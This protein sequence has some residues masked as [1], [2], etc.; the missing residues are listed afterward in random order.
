MTPRSSPSNNTAFYNIFTI[1][2]L[3]LS[4]SFR[5]PLHTN[6]LIVSRQSRRCYGGSPLEYLLRDRDVRLVAR[7][8]RGD[9]RRIWKRDEDIKDIFNTG[10][11]IYQYIGVSPGQLTG[12]TKSKATITRQRTKFAYLADVHS[13]SFFSHNHMS[14]SLQERSLICPQSWNTR[15]NPEREI[16]VTTMDVGKQELETSVISFDIG[17]FEGFGIH[18]YSWVTHL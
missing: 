4:Y 14:S 7:R 3:I 2:L 10:P 15:R 16:P 9:D 5:D 6:S 12:G 13:T 8:L 1:A 18:K 11:S 17:M